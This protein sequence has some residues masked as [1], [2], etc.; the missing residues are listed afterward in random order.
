MIQDTRSSHRQSEKGC[1]GK[2]ASEK[3]SYERP[4][5]EGEC[6]VATMLAADKGRQQA[7]LKS[8]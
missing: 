3:T 7:G 4:G 6:A 1:R 5:V 8:N 2:L